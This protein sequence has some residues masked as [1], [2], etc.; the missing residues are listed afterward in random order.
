MGLPAEYP[1][2]LTEKK[3]KH[4]CNPNKKA[5]LYRADRLQTIEHVDKKSY[6]KAS[7]HHFI[8]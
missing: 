3:S 7:K 5:Y 6:P 2:R 8:I 4:G 1:P